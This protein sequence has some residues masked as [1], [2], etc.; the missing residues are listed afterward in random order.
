V[1]PVR[2]FQ[3]FPFNQGLLDD[4]DRLP[5]SLVFG[6]LQVEDRRDAQGVFQEGLG[7]R[8]PRGEQ[9]PGGG[10]CPVADVQTLDTS[11]VSP[12]TGTQTL[13]VERGSLSAFR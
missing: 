10:G 11:Q 3:A 6:E 5:V 13:M 8:P 9:L 12:S 1:A 4:R 7:L 2:A